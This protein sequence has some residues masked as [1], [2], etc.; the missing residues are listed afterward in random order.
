MATIKIHQH[1]KAPATPSTIELEAL[2]FKFNSGSS[3][4]PIWNEL[5]K[6]HIIT[7]KP[8]P[9]HKATTIANAVER[10]KVKDHYYKVLCEMQYGYQLTLDY[11]YSAEQDCESITI[12]LVDKTDKLN[13]IN[14]L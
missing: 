14:L 4:M 9:G 12:K 10:L 13:P 2:R 11:R 6:H 7:A 1:Q 3:Y 8:L 5:K